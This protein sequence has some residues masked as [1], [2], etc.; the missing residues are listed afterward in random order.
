MNTVAFSPDGKLL[1]SAG[2]DQDILLWDVT[3][4]SAPSR[5]AV[6]SGHTSTVRSLAF[7]GDGKTL[8]SAGDGRIVRLW[9]VDTAEPIGGSLVG[10]GSG[11]WNATFSPSGPIVAAGGDGGVVTILDLDESHATDRICRYTG[12]VL[13]REEWA[14]HLPAL[15][16][17]PPCD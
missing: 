4:P 2:D 1:A 11:R 7:A 13:T 16:Y 14:R 5:T 3:D 6:L 10:G 12:N 15:D 8:V 17:D 9:D